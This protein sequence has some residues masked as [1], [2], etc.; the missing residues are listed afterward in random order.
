MKMKMMIEGLTIAYCANVIEYTCGC[1]YEFQL[2]GAYAS[3]PT[4]HLIPC[5]NHNKEREI[6]ERQAGLDWERITSEVRS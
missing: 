4:P 3:V 2:I 1:K 6:I 5:Y